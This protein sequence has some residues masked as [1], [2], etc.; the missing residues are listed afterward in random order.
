MTAAHFN[1]RVQLEG[2]FLD[3]LSYDEI[4]AILRCPQKLK[5]YESILEH[6][7]FFRKTTLHAILL[8][9]AQEDSSW[10]SEDD[11]KNPR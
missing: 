9:R 2:R 4:M 3:S 10:D 8:K 11:Q 5:R 6:V 1:F 7:L